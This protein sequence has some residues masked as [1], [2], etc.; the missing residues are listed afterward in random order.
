MRCGCC[1]KELGDFILDY[2]FQLPDA[3]WDLSPKER[4]KR[5]KYDSDLA[6]LDHRYFLRGILQLPIISTNEQFRWGIW[7]EVGQ[8]KFMSYVKNYSDD[9]SHE[10]P[11]DGIIAN[12][13][14]G[15][16]NTIGVYVK[17]QLGDRS[18]R[19]RFLVVGNKNL[20]AIDQN[21]GV[22]LGR[23]HEFTN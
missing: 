11:F 16:S 18:S 10:A 12:Q 1:G 14:R 2:G 4:E 22:T 23:I 7:V 13:L 8:N 17:V 6:Q 5:A 15:Y 19:P 3:I 9:N 20:L 21:E